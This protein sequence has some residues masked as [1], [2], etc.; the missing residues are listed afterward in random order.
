MSKAQDER[1]FLALT[2]KI[3]RARGVSCG[4]YKDKCLK[5]RIAVRMR[6]SVLIV[7]TVSAI[8]NASCSLS[9]SSVPSRSPRM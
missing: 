6:E 5:R 4:S 9:I 2:E 8:T 1:A 7:L 3:S